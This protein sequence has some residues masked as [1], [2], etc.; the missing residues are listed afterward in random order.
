M[1]FSSLQLLRV[2]R[3]Q[4][5][6]YRNTS[7]ES[8]KCIARSAKIPEEHEDGYFDFIS[9]TSWK[10]TVFYKRGRFCY[11]DCFTAPDGKRFEIN[12]SN[13]VLWGDWRALQ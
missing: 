6:D 11:I 2:K 10:V 8:L 7:E 5:K 13:P 3:A 9:E 4:D 12:G 1:L